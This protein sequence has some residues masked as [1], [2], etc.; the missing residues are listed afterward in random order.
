MAERVHC[1]AC[2][3]P[4]EFAITTK[5]SRIPLNIDSHPDANIIIDD[6]GVAHV[7][8]KGQGVRISHF[9]TCTQPKRFRRRDRTRR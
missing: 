6:T 5:G 9:A 4:I 2:D 8:P 1:K 3:A 7:V